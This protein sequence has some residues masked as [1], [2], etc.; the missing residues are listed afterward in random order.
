MFLFYFSTFATLV[1]TSE[2][3]MGSKALIDAV[4][5]PDQR[6][7]SVSPV[8]CYFTFTETIRTVK[9]GTYIFLLII[10]FL[11]GQRRQSRIKGDKCVDPKCFCDEAKTDERKLLAM[12]VQP[13]SVKIMLFSTRLIDST[14]TKDEPYSLRECQE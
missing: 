6:N 9:D 2:L 13:Q 12:A 5:R 14:H 1:D 10:L 8:Q 7:I 3:F 4:N 11:T